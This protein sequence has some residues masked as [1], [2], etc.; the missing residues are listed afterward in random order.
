MC[1]ADNVQGGE[2]S[3]PSALQTG[4]NA[5]AKLI[6]RLKADIRHLHRE[7]NDARAGGDDEKRMLLRLQNDADIAAMDRAGLLQKIASLEA[8][9]RFADLDGCVTHYVRQ[10]AE[11][12][13][14]GNCTFVDDDLKLLTFCARWAL[15]NGIPDE[16][17]PNIFPKAK[18]AVSQRPDEEARR[19]DTATAEERDGSLTQKGTDA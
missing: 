14:A 10:S 5:D 15:Q 4:D 2:G 6:A 13:F 1:Q 12:V 7:L 16:L 18:A 17:C 8:K 9:Y 19:A 11:E 3:S